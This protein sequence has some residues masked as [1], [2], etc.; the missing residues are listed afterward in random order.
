MK[1]RRLSGTVLN[2]RAVVICR[3]SHVD[4]PPCCTAILS[5]AFKRCAPGYVDPTLLR[6]EVF[7]LLFVVG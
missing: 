1:S 4:L 6:D 2:L 3:G 5:L 7:C